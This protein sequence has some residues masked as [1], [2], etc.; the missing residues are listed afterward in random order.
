MQRRNL[1]RLE[2][3]YKD[4]GK[5]SG[6]IKVLTFCS[7]LIQENWKFVSSVTFPH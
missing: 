4:A 6:D 5:R 7:L 2:K 3:C 1:R